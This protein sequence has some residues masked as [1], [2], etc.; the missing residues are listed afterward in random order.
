MNM[1]ICILFQSADTWKKA[2]HLH[3]N[4]KK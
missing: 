3:V 1:R 2:T 4:C